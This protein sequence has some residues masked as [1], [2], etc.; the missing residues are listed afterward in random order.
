MTLS[1]KDNKMIENFIEK[2]DIDLKH[3]EK[4]DLSK[5]NVA[6]RVDGEITRKVNLEMERLDIFNA[7]SKKHPYE[8][9]FAA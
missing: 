2:Y 6:R 7:K 1:E 5:P 3:P 4:Y 9:F 8:Y